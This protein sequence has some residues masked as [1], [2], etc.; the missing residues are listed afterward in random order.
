MKICYEKQSRTGCLLNTVEIRYHLIQRGGTKCSLLGEDS[1]LS[2]F[3]WAPDLTSRLTA[4]YF[5]AAWS[6]HPVSVVHPH[7]GAIWGN[8]PTVTVLTVLERGALSL[9]DKLVRSAQ[10]KLSG[11]RWHHLVSAVPTCHPAISVAT[12]LFI[13]FRKKIT[14]HRYLYLQAAP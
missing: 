5:T 12:D 7:G 10:G 6:A 8:G 1:K 3:L 14:I 2:R 11:H 13:S 4:P 9:Q